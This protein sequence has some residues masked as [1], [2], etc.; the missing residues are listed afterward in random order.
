MLK[1]QVLSFLE[2]F[3]SHACLVAGFILIT[4]GLSQPNVVL[5]I[6]GIW[7]IGL[8]V[9]LAFTFSVRKIYQKL[10]Q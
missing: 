3:L 9:C 7:L 5:N 2:F 1:L 8:G 4:L 6:I 10:T